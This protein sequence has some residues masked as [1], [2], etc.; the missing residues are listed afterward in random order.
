MAMITSIVEYMPLLWLGF[1]IFF[2][3]F[4]FAN[5]GFFYFLSFSCASFS[6]AIASICLSLPLQIV[7]FSLMTI[8]SFII[9]IFHAKK[10]MQ[11]HL[12]RTNVSALIGKKGSVIREIN[13][14]N[15]FGY[16][17][18]DN[19]QWAARSVDLTTIEKDQIIEV[20]TV[21]GAHLIVKKIEDTL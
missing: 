11:R 15:S 10:L 3:I 2:I 14:I 8:F 13:P 6:A 1:T 7:I 21:K 17:I 4:E 9:L 5:P 19:Q 12:F 20:I 16:V 18:I